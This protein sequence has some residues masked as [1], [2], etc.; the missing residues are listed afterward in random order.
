M[1]I[2]SQVKSTPAFGEVVITQWQKA[3]LLKP[4]VV[5]PVLTTVGKRL[6]LRRLGWLGPR[7]RA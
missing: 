3:G 5:K 7:G 6:M 2:T 1:A 4:S